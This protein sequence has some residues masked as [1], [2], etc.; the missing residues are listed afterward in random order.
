[1]AMAAAWQMAVAV[2]SSLLVNERSAPF[3]TSSTV[4]MTR[5]LTTRGSVA[6]LFFS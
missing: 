1:M 6:Q 4:P 5:S 2:S 3:S